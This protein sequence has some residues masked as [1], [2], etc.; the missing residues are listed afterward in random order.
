MPK[1]FYKTLDAMKKMK[2]EGCFMTSK[3]LPEE[4]FC[5]R[6]EKNKVAPEKFDLRT[7]KW[8]TFHAPTE[9][10]GWDWY[11]ICSSELSDMCLEYF[12]M[13]GWKK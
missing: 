10:L 1:K 12:E 8:K 2:V 4:I 13:V 7:K 6:V 9:S 3:S 5:V 11:V